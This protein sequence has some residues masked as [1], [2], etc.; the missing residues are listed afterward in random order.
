M[1]QFI[2]GVALLVF[3]I[4]GC[5]VPE[6]DQSSNWRGPNRDGIYHETNLLQEWP[7]TG[8][9][10]LWE[11]DQLGEGYCSVAIA[12]NTI[13]TA[14][15]I[16]SISFLF[17]F[18]MNGQL[19]WEKELG[20]EWVKTFPGMRSTP[21]IDNGLGYI[22][23]G[24]GILFCFNSENGAI[25]WTKD[26]VKDF[27]AKEIM[28]GQSENLLINGDYLY[29]TPGGKE[30][31]VVALNKKTGDLIW[32]SPGLGEI[33]A[34][35]SPILFERGGKKFI[36]TNTFKSVICLNA[37]SGE[38]AWSHTFVGQKYGI[39]PHSHIYRDGHLMVSDGFEIGIFMLKI[40]EDGTSVEKLWENNLMD[41]TNGHQVRVGD[42]IYGA[43]ETK[44]KF[45]GVDWNTGET[46][47]EMRKFTP[48]TVI[49]TS[50]GML[51]TYSY[52]GQLGL[53][54]PLED[55]FEIKGS[56][57]LEKR[58]EIHIAHPVIH[59]GIL[60]IRYMNQLIAY[61][62][63]ELYLVC[64]A[65]LRAQSLRPVRLL[66]PCRVCPSDCR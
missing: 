9:Q 37:E 11:F 42:M 22:L 17:A 35:C 63:F 25:V 4:N 19:K 12:N 48:G 3:I 46:K 8:P 64:V 14:G 15:T 13:Y 2:T 20:P 62:I 18:D 27:G 26:Y 59:N 39:H 56:F 66:L 50:D 31:N 16:D 28:H 47:I 38:L 58:R 40:S 32:K 30:Y 29:C 60:Y 6:T 52:G 10:K 61:D 65:L 21:S 53:L 43:A 45:I 51:Y 5:S 44:K 41:E 1:R 7:E 23:N 49:A 36:S 57:K 54:K 34:Y 33:P 24:L 55:S